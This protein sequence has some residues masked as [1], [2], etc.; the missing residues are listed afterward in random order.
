MEILAELGMFSHLFSAAYE[1][2]TPVYTNHIETAA[3]SNIVYNGVSHIVYLINPDF[4]FSLTLEEQTFIVAHESL[5]V[6]FNHLKIVKEEKLNANIANIAADVVINETLVRHYGFNRSLFP[7]ACFLDTI[8]SED[9][10]RHYQLSYTTGFIKLY[11]IL[12]NDANKVSQY[13]NSSNSSFDEHNIDYSEELKEDIKKELDKQEQNTNNQNKQ[14]AQQEQKDSNGESENGDSAND[15]NHDINESNQIG[16]NENQQNSSNENNQEISG[17]EKQNSNASNFNHNN[18]DDGIDSEANEIECSNIFDNRIQEEL[19]RKSQLDVPKIRQQMAQ[20]VSQ[21]FDKEC[22]IASIRLQTKR[23]SKKWEKI[24]NFV[25]PTL[26]KPIFNKNESFA[27]PDFY[28]KMALPK[29]TK[30]IFPTM[31]DE[32]EWGNDLI[33]LYFFFDTSGSCYPF[34]NEFIQIVSEIPKNQFRLHLFNFDTKVRKIDLN[35]PLSSIKIDNGN[36]PFQI[37]EEQIQY[38]LKSKIITKYPDL[39]C[40]LTDGM[41]KPLKKISEK[42]MKSWLWLILTGNVSDSI[43]LQKRS[44]VSQFYAIKRLKSIPFYDTLFNPDNPKVNRKANGCKIMP[45]YSVLTKKEKHQK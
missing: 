42:H 19:Q 7:D 13:Q 14:D 45:M 23:E 8:F 10:I 41:A 3:V 28:I 20:D 26:L 24:V 30:F 21:S 17:D 37:L 4:F 16:D 38:D 5:H 1:L 35:Q 11:D 36:A 40:V 43:D 22:S 6:Y 18:E 25:K 9:E 15:K 29:D 44:F 12:I 32:E 39:V 2:G 27:I 34:L 31:Q 33:D